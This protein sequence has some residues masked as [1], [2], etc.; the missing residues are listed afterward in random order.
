M[1]IIYNI[2]NFNTS[3]FNITI[4]ILFT[5]SSASQDIDYYSEYSSYIN[6]TQES[7]KPDLYFS[8]GVSYFYGDKDLNIKKNDAKAVF[9]LEKAAE[10]GVP[11]A[12]D[13]MGIAYIVSM[14]VKQDEMKAFYWDLKAAENKISRAQFRVGQSYSLG[15]GVIENYKSSYAWFAV[16]A[17]STKDQG[18]KDIAI[19]QRD[20][21]KEGLSLE[22]LVEAQDLATK[23][24]DEIYSE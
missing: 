1:S 15:R 14:G 8:I 4:F 7:E 10:H 6:K 17:L 16:A 13:L 12:Q 5:F 11:E 23:L 19:K 24:Y 3:F 9:W 22:A 21:M 2:W 20:Y 18:R